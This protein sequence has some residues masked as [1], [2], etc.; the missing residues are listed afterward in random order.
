VR[1]VS[2][3]A[4]LLGSRGRVRSRSGVGKFLRSIQ[5]SLFGRAPWRPERAP[6]AMTVPGWLAGIAL[7]AAFAG[8][9]LVGDRF[10]G[11]PGDK[12]G[13]QI[14]TGESAGFIHEADTAPLSSNGF[15]VALYQGLPA[16]DASVRAKALSSWLRERGLAKARPYESQTAYGPVWIVVVYFDGDT[17]FKA[18]RQRL[19]EL[20]DAVPDASFTDLRKSYAEEWPK[21]KRIG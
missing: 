20:P 9:F 7:L 15:I 14:R 17:E 8:G 11:T 2:D 12:S 16:A 10:G 21:A 13:L 3:M 6:K 4:L 18:T 5:E 19:L 1:K